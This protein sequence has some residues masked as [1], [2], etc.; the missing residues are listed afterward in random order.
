MKKREIEYYESD[1]EFEII[2]DSSELANGDFEPED[3]GS[4]AVVIHHVVTV[5]LIIA[6]FAI[7]TW[8]YLTF[9]STSFFLPVKDGSEKSLKPY[10]V[11]SQEDRLRRAINVYYKM[12]GNYPSSLDD[13][14]DDK[15]LVPSDPYYPPNSEF[16][17]EKLASS[18]A[19]EIVNIKRESPK[20]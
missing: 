15:I 8:S 5:V 10:L 16:R 12:N 17:Y 1:E 20:K 6:C 7:G 2:H 13:I 9:K 14:V 4:G 18:Y 3:S 19:L 11:K